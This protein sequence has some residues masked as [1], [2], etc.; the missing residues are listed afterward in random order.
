MESIER[1]S[2]V[3]GAESVRKLV[4]ILA[5][6]VAILCL[7]SSM[8]LANPST[9]TRKAA[10]PSM[11]TGIWIA[12]G[13]GQEDRDGFDLFEASATGEAPS[14]PRLQEDGVVENERASLSLEAKDPD[15]RQTLSNLT[16]GS[17]PDASGYESRSY[18]LVKP[19]RGATPT[20]LLVEERSNNG[21][22]YLGLLSLAIP[23]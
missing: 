8:A 14:M 11:M 9:G 2:S 15:R 5:L 4:G 3:R 17:G 18:L 16:L 7:V 20:I 13:T 19:T 12:C 10:G 22:L 6:A 1:R 23:W 21:T